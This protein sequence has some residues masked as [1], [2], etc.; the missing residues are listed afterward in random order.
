[1][2][3]ALSAAPRRS[4]A[5]DLG[6]DLAVE[7]REL[8]AHLIDPA[9]V[10][11]EVEEGIDEADLFFLA[12]RNADDLALAKEVTGEELARRER[13]AVVGVAGC[14]VVLALDGV[15]AAVG[16]AC[17]YCDSTVEI[18]SLRELRVVVLPDLRLR[19]L[20][21]EREAQQLNRDGLAAA[22]GSEHGGKA[23]MEVKVEPIEEPTGDL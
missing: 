8:L 23:F 13:G 19:R 4:C 5:P 9:L 16:E 10:R 7:G 2:S 1:V 14:R 12:F 11:A 18:E 22:L 15:F 21:V 3:S 20:L 17:S 6:S